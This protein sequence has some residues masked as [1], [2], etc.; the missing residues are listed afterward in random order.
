MT[1][2][3]AIAIPGSLRTG[4]INRAAL[5][6][7]AELA[8]AGFEI[9]IHGLEGIPLYNADDERA[10]GFPPPVD[11]LRE[12]VAGADALLIAT[13]EYNSSTTGALKN[14]IDWLSR[15]PDS[16]LAGK[17]AAILGA[18][19]RFGTLRAQLHLREILLGNQVDLVLFPQV[20]I[21]LAS[22]R[23]DDDLRLT[24][25]RFRDQ[26]ERLLT[27]LVDKVTSRN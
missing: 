27:A 2:I 3:T 16:P 8:P 6:A 21:D 18:G 19:G 15:R 4:S 12:A 10:A 24:D 9:T 25:E 14:A 23:F 20:M 5:A 7:A 11:A 17:P 22:T 26:I 13:P 1:T